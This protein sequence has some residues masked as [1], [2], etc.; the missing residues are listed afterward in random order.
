MD[1][2]ALDVRGTEGL[3]AHR[4]Y[5]WIP[6]LRAI[7]GNVGL[8]GGLH[9]WTADTKTKDERAAWIAQLDEMD[10][11]DPRIVV[12]GHMLRGTALDRGAI[13]HTRDWLRDFEALLGR[14]DSSRAVV[15]TM[16]ARYPR[17]G[18]EM[19]LELGAAVAIDD[20]PW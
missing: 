6:A 13:A 1:G 7:V 4:P 12:P 20:A 14:A 11:L 5:V 17:A 18:F 8:F 9:V 10:A 15:E 16:K 19:A 2:H 3:L